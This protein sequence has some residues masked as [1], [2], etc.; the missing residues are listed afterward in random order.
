MIDPQ[1]SK[2]IV[3]AAMPRSQLWFLCRDQHDLARIGKSKLAEAGGSVLRDT[4]WRGRT[5]DG[6]DLSR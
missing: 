1:R 3:V 2:G 5:W 6:D 4:C